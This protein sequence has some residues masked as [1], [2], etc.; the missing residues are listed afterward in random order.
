MGAQ[1]ARVSGRRD[2]AA[3]ADLLA[4]RPPVD[5]VLVSS[6]RRA[7]QTWSRVAAAFAEPDVE[8]RAD[9]YLADRPSL[10]AIVRALP[11]DASRVLVI[12]HNGGLEDLATDLCG[13]SVGLKTCTWATM[14]TELPWNRWTLHGQRLVEVVTARA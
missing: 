6:A 8:V 10:L 5:V 3:A 11:S 9:L 2:A 4:A 7:R 1:I 13:Q 14:E 12:G